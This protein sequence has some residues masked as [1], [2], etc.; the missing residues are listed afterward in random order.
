MAKVEFEGITFDSEWEKD[1]YI[2]LKDTV[3]ALKIKYH[4]KPIF[5]LV[6]RKQYTP[7]F[8]YQTNNT[9]VW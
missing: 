4:P 8:I 6:A 2:Y 9:I 5:D 1:Y 7:D 3:K